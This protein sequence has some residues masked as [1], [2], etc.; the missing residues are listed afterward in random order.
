MDMS[1]VELIELIDVTS[2]YSYVLSKFIPLSS[3]VC[4]ITSTEF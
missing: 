2:A 3:H 1:L 4:S